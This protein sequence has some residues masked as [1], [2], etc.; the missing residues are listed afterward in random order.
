MLFENSSRRPADLATAERWAS[1]FGRTSPIFP[2]DAYAVYDLYNRNDYQP[3]Y[4]LI[5]KF[6]VVAEYWT[7]WNESVIETAIQ[8]ELAR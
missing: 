8:R 5:D 6:G 3:Q 1:D 2:D 7:S 4:I